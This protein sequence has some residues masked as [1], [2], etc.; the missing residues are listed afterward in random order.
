MPTVGLKRKYHNEKLE[1]FVTN[2]DE[3]DKI[4][5]F[6]NELIQKTDPVYL[7]PTQ[8]FIK[9]HFYAPRK[10]IFGRYMDTF[11]VNIIVIWTMTLVFYL[12]LYFRLLKRFLDSFEGMST[13]KENN[14]KE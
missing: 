2:K 9:A 6:K 5:E 14:N 13:G 11:W 1:D 8:K 10:M 3:T 12:I 4:V 7:D